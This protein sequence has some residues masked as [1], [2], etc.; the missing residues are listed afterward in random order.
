MEFMMLT[1]RPS[2]IRA[3]TEL[4]LS[5]ISEEKAV[6]T[7]TAGEVDHTKQGQNLSSTQTN[8]VMDLVEKGA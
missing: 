3:E 1:G 2:D 5:Q 4:A 6:I 7:V 8:T